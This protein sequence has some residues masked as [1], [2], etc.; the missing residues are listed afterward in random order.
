MDGLA[1]FISVDYKLFYSN[2]QFWILIW[3]GIFQILC[4][5]IHIVYANLT[6]QQFLYQQVI[7]LYI[8]SN[9]V[10]C[11]LW[12]SFQQLVFYRQMSRLLFVVALLLRRQH[13]QPLFLPQLRCPNGPILLTCC[14]VTL[15]VNLC[16]LAVPWPL[17]LTSL[18]FLDNK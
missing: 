16:Y 1:N 2:F 5:F 9:C 14:I 10:G 3:L 13:F 11:M 17:T 4:I 15:P 12:L 18:K 8:K 6:K 7:I